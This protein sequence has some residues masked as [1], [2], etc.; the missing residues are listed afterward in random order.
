MEHDRLIAS[1]Q[2]MLEAFIQEDL[3]AADFDALAAQT[4]DDEAN[5][6]LC[7][8]VALSE[9]AE[10]QDEEPLPPTDQWGR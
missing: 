5:A 6:E 4:F 1:D 2:A 7:Y 3:L 8:A 9:Q 10:A